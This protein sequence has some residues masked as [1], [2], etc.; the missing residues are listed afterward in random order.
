VADRFTHGDA[1][2]NLSINWLLWSL[3]QF[4]PNFKHIRNP[5]VLVSG[6]HCLFCDQSSY[7]LL[8]LALKAGIRARHVGLGGLVVM[9]AW[10]DGNW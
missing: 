10:Y 8:N 2:H 3:G 1:E 4:N 7:L 5:Q 9:E 6:G